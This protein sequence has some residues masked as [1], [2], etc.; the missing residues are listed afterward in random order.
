MGLGAYAPAYTVFDTLS[1]L[2]M[3]EQA[4]ND[5]LQI[6]ADAGIIGLVIGIAFLILFFREGLRN[7]R[8]QNVSR[9]GIAVGAF[10][11]CSAILIHSLFDFVLH[12]T[13]IS[14]L[15]LALMAILVASGRKFEDET[16]EFDIPQRKRRRSA[17]VTPIDKRLAI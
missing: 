11:G 7:I 1:G 6:M 9:R 16:N 17:S 13:A 4:H 12:I 5:Y 2:E 10:A 14:V 15:F 3:V 8:V